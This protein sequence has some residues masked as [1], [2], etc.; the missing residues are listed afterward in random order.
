MFVLFVSHQ[1]LHT[2][3]PDPTGQQLDVLRKVLS[4]LIAGELS[5][6]TDLISQTYRSSETFAQQRLQN[7]YLWMDW[8]SI[9]QAFQDQMNIK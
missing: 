9:P 1:W 7:A 3:H 2:G 4:G 5:V 8:F 6:E